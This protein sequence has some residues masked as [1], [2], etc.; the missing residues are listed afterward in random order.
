MDTRVRPSRAEGLQ[1]C[2]HD[3]G[4]LI[5]DPHTGRTWSLNP[6]GLL[7]WDHCDGEHDLGQIALEIRLEFGID[8]VQAQRDA[9]AFLAEMQEQGLLLANAPTMR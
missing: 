7:I 5:I 6:V 2:T 9:A 3:D 8:L 4:G 1:W